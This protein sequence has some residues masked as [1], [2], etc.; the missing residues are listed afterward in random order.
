AHDGV[1]LLSLGGRFAPK[2]APDA[3]VIDATSREGGHGELRIAVK[4]YVQQTRLRLPFR[5]PWVVLAGHRQGE[6]HASLHLASQRFAYDLVQT[7][8]GGETFR[9]DQRLPTSYL[10]Y[11]QPVLAAADGIVVQINDSVPDNTPV[12]WRP[13]W[14]VFLQRPA[15]LAGNFVVLRHRG[16]EHTAYFHLKKGLHLHVGQHVKAGDVL[17]L[18]GNSGNSVEPHLHFQLQRGP[19]PLHARGLPARFSNFTWRYGHLA[20]YI[21]D[22]EKKS[23]P[24]PERLVI[25]PGRPQ[26]VLSAPTSRGLPAT[27]SRNA[28]K[29]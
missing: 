3:I 8:A 29:R 4:T 13:S 19:D 27:P 9:G 21:G 23:S 5:G 28:K 14:H 1:S 10:A 2:L 11:D 24:L 7:R 12:G 16:N 6:P 17:G 25:A 15:D 22:E 26:G 20:R 18:C